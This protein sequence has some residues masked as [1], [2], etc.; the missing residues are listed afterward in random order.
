MSTRSLQN[1]ARNIRTEIIKM[2]FESKSAHVSSSLC[3]ADILTVLYWDIMKIN[4]KK[5]NLK[6]RDKFILSKGHAASALYAILAE[7]GYFSKKLLTMYNKNGT[8]LGDHPIYG[9]PGVELATGSLGHGLS[10][11][12]GMALSNKI[13]KSTARVY[14]LVSDA[15]CQ[16]GTIWEALLL[17][18]QFKLNN[19]TLI[20]DYNKLQ[21]F[22]R[23][24]DVIELEP[25]GEKIKAFGW[26][27][28]SIDGHSVNQLKKTLGIKNP[29]KPITVICNTIGGRGVKFLEDNWEW[30]Y[31]NIN[32]NQYELA[33]KLINKK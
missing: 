10:V 22:G 3:I 4:P 16:E 6:N 13:S 23:V 2:A 26:D 27:V 14:V 31:K 15:E 18:S 30:H 33:V 21:A 7:K 20:I 29:S 17:A 28:Y 32:K 5:P 8:L 19:L 12:C 9:T 24:S 25:L 1:K 11:A